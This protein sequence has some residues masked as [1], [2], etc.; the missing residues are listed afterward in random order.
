MCLCSHSDKVVKEAQHSHS[1]HLSRKGTPL[2]R[3]SIIGHKNF[4]QILMSMANTTSAFRTTE[5]TGRLLVSDKITLFS[6]ATKKP[7]VTVKG[8]PS[9]KNS[10]SCSHSMPASAGESHPNFKTA[11]CRYGNRCIYGDKCRSVYCSIGIPPP[12]LSHSVT[13]F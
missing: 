8:V 11:M 3:I 5:C 4:N 10:A 2:E 13:L 1:K 6:K 7:P 12:S 9:E